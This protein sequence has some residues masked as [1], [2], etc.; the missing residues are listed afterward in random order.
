MRIILI[1]LLLVPFAGKS[2]HLQDSLWGNKKF[3]FGISLQAGATDWSQSNFNNI[4]SQNNAPTTREVN[5]EACFGDILQW[6]KL[7][8]TA[9]VVMW[10]NKHSANSVKIEQKFTGSELN[11]EYFIIRKRGFSLSPLIGGGRVD[12]ITKV[13]KR[14]TPQ[15]FSNALANSTTTEL[16]NKQ[17]YLNAAINFGFC[18]APRLK[19]HLYQATVGYRIGFANTN[20]STDPDVEI[21]TGSTTDALSQLYVSLKMNVLF[22]SRRHHV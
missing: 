22:L 13:I 6:D 1:L 17:G 3:R 4:L 8:I 19:D 14:A 5:S 10:R 12:G 11:V 9:L 15:S 2:Q 21:L 7:R 16:F 18:Y 20:W